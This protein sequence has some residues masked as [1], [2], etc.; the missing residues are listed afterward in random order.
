MCKA[1]HEELVCI[2]H[3]QTIPYSF[4]AQQVFW[5]SPVT[6]VERSPEAFTAENVTLHILQ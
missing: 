2:G 5:L 3:P 1:E 4:K 6:A